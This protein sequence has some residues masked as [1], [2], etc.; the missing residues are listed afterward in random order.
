MWYNLVMRTG[1]IEH[2]GKIKDLDRSFDLAFWQSQEPQVRFAA[3]WDLIV[4]A[5]ITKGHDVRQ[6]RLQRFVE[7]FQHQQSA[8]S[9]NRR[10]RR[11]PIRRTPLY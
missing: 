10:L 9:C 8:L 11:R 4:H 5:F 6:L 2:R 1:I 7:T 3:T